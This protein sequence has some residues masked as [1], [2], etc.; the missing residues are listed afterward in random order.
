MVDIT[1]DQAGP[2]RRRVYK[3]AAWHLLAILLLLRDLSFAAADQLMLAPEAPNPPDRK[4]AH[5]PWASWHSAGQSGSVAAFLVPSIVGR[6]RE[7]RRSTN[8]SRQGN[9]GADGRP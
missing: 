4:A 8:L 9:R 5:S 6:C 7:S 2:G 3:T 1:A